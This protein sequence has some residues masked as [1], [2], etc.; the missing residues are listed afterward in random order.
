M[1][2]CYVTCILGL[3]AADKGSHDGIGMFPLHVRMD[4]DLLHARDARSLPL[5][6][7]LSLAGV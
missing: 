7:Q 6:H 1:A 2:S 3:L 5:H 4:P